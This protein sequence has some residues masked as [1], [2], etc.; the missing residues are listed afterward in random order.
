MCWSL[1]RRACWRALTGF[2]AGLGQGTSQTMED[3]L[4][5]G[6]QVARAGPTESALRAYEAVRCE[7]EGLADM[8][9]VVSQRAVYG[10]WLGT[11]E[12]K[13]CEQWACSR[14][15]H[16]AVRTTWCGGVRLTTPLMRCGQRSGRAAARRAPAAGAVQKASADLVRN[17]GRL[18]EKWVL[19]EQR[20]SEQFFSR[21]F[22]PLVPR[23]LTRTLPGPGEA[24]PAGPP[25][26]APALRACRG[27][28]AARPA[29]CAGG[30]A[31]RAGLGLGPRGAGPSGVLHARLL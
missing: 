22:A 15:C 7:P 17:W 26:R 31:R 19:A 20:A 18:A 4:E 23:T 13:R 30:A 9:C 27:R 12:N 1:E 6:R 3:A 16:P 21:E 11:V 29:R 14:S 5:L 10:T 8:L 24:A 28:G 25:P 2:S